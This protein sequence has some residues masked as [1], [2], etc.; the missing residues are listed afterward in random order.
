M[1]EIIDILLF[2]VGGSVG[3]LFSGIKLRTD[4]D[5]YI[6]LSIEQTFLRFSR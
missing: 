1:K 6:I 4:K 2:K 3:I 5:C